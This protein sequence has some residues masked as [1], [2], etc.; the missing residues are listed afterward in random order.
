MTERQL[1]KEDNEDHE[2]VCF[3]ND[4]NKGICKLQSNH[5][6]WWEFRSLW[7]NNDFCSSSKHS[8]P[9]AIIE[10]MRCQS[11]E[12]IAVVS[13]YAMDEQRNINSNNRFTQEHIEPG[14]VIL[15]CRRQQRNQGRH[16]CRERTWCLCNRLTCKS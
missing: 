11:E 2:R 4:N 10:R 7:L 15:P 6:T 13:A 16:T 12:F 8:S 14:L 3:F 5:F 9:H 1:M